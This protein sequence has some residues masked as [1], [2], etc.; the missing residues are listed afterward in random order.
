M[1]PTPIFT[2]RTRGR[3]LDRGAGLCRTF[4]AR[5][6][7]E[8]LTSDRTTTLWSLALQGH[9]KFQTGHRV[10]EPAGKSV[11]VDELEFGTAV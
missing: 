11:D 3:T 10:V 8:S 1:G 4:A 5:S 9:I 7:E 6:L 2:V